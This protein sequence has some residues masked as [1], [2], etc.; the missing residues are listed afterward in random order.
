MSD[1]TKKP[2]TEEAQKPEGETPQITQS[3]SDRL[4]DFM[5][6]FLMAGKISSG[7]ITMEEAIRRGRES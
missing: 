1:E 3:Q 5:S 4:N 7:E 6:V 2:I